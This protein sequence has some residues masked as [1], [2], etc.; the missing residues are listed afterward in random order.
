MDR[1]TFLLRALGSTLALSPLGLDFQL[2]RA[3]G[4]GLSKEEQ[5]CVDKGLTWLASQQHR[6][7]H[8]E[9]NGGAYPTAM[10]AL[11]GMALI[12]EGSTLREGKYADKIRRAVD[13]FVERAQPNGLLADT[14]NPTEARQYMYGHG[15]GQLFLASLHGEEEEERRRKQLEE[16]LTKAV[17][18]TGEA[19]SGAGGWGYVSAKD[20]N[21]DEGSV[22]ITQ[23]QALRAA[24]NA[25]I[26]V[27]KEVLDKTREYLEKKC[28]GP[29]DMVQYRPGQP[30]ITPGLTTA[31]VACYFCAGEY[32]A[33]IVKRWLKALKQRIGALGGGA[34]RMGH[35]EYTHYYWAQSL[36]ILGEDG[37]ERLFP[38]TPKAEQL[39]WSGYRKVTYP[40]L[41]KSQGSDG[42]WGSAAGSQW[43]GIGAV[44]VT[45]MFLTILQLEKGT[46]PI[47][48]R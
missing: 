32:D 23:M 48:Q 12:M 1:R 44:Y 31:G 16:V 2:G 22:T 14:R 10:T 36:Y 27:S 40:A 45:S 28:T 29:D 42:S 9:A 20:Q 21:F 18:F 15:F 33:P 25:G 8:W 3:R 46:L 7:G 19:Q 43:A 39:N 17:K 30:A 34:G 4:E 35:D 5:D 6:D 24:R 37:W 26:V 11:A 47:Y 41:M 13:W 38:G